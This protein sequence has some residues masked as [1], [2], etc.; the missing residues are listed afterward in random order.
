M[1]LEENIQSREETR[2]RTAAEHLRAV[3]T[4]RQEVD[5]LRTTLDLLP[6]VIFEANTQ[7][8]VTFANEYAFQFFGASAQQFREGLN[9][10]DFVAPEDVP[11]LR[12][13][14]SA[15]LHGSA[16]GANEYVVKNHAGESCSVVVYS[17]AIRDRNGDGVGVRGI[18]VDITSRKKIETTLR[19]S[20]SRY[21]NLFMTIDDAAFIYDAASGEILD[22]NPAAEQLYGYTHG[23]LLEMHIAALSAT[24]HVAGSSGPADGQDPYPASPLQYHKKSNG[25]VFPV[26]MSSGAFEWENRRCRFDIYRDLAGRRKAELELRRSEAR[27]KLYLNAMH[28]GLLD[29]DIRTGEMFY[30]PGWI[31]SLGYEPDEVPPYLSFWKS[32]IHR[33]D[34]L[35]L[36]SALD[37]HFA[38]RIPKV[39]TEVRM[40]TKL[41]SWRWMGCRGSVVEW[42]EDGSPSRFIATFADVSDRKAAEER[43]QHIADENRLL[44]EHAS[45]AIFIINEAGDIL[46]V[47]TKCCE[48]FEYTRTELL[49]LNVHEM[50]PPEEQDVAPLPFEKLRTGVSL[51]EDRTFRNKSGALI[52]IEWSLKSMPDGRIHSSARNITERKRAES[53]F[54]SI[55][56]SEVYEKLFIK[57]RVFKHGE[58]MAMN[59]N[60]LML[61]A[62]NITDLHA[63][64]LRQRESETSVSA[65]LPAA[66]RV[67][68]AVNEYNLLVYP[69][70]RSI[71]LLLQAIGEEQKHVEG[72]S[73]PCASGRELLKLNENV[74]LL[75]G[76]MKSLVTD[77][78]RGGMKD[79][80]VKSLRRDMLRDVDTLKRHV[81]DLM[82]LVES[83]LA[84]DVAKTVATVA[85]KYMPNALGVPIVLGENQMRKFA[86]GKPGEI[87][88]IVSILIHNALQAM[89]SDSNHEQ[90]RQIDVNCREHDGKILIVV[91]DTGPGV[92]E[93]LR[94]KIFED[95]FTTKS[96]GHGFGLSYARSALKKYGGRITCEQHHP[97]GARFLIELVVL[98]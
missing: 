61:F 24:G 31:Q 18:L 87:G 59:L 49:A 93:H 58:S 78:E 41:Q 8:R 29:W 6:T 1:R 2:L 45:D 35:R 14:L 83:E 36:Q 26:E 19:E 10:E 38:G 84:C 80:E 16:G 64:L 79:D 51:V 50:V 5:R 62:Q 25:A 86:I 12:Q 60:R 63:M 68:V 90:E 48:L 9:I 53:E 13:N 75:I 73:M 74:K 39:I 27:L 92:P 91:D 97:R 72:A 82:K 20:E 95:G 15:I 17:D 67:H 70:L 44:M 32:L 66:Q 77:P 4:L 3:E 81:N 57:L 71:G 98:N 54:K 22:A 21:K 34:M 55:I 30:S 11:R 89:E 7:G 85:G 40:R 43:L 76:E 88:E 28:D 37:E 33:D 69:E 47:N 56:M 94:E 23:D 65:H 42:N 52:C 96:D 46:D